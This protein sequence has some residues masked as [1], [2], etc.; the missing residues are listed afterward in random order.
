MANGNGERTVSSLEARAQTSLID[1]AGSPLMT[2]P[3]R[4]IATGILV[5]YLGI[6]GL[7]ALVF[8]AWGVV[9]AA[10]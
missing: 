2:R 6:A 8:F 5:G 1:M 9:H 3:V 7:S 4:T 10:R